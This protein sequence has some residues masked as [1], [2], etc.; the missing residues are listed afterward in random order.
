MAR[1]TTGFM[2]P[3]KRAPKPMSKSTYTLPST[4]V[5]REPA[6]WR[7]TIGWGSKNWMLEGTPRGSTLR[8]R[9]MAMRD[10]PVRAA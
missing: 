3:A 8:A 9:S 4:S 7:T 6:A 10:P 2:C 5:I 1:R